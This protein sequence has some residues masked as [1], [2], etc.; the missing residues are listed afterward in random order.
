MTDARDVVAGVMDAFASVPGAAV[1]SAALLALL[2]LALGWIAGRPARRA[3]RW[4]QRRGRADLEAARRIEDPARL[5]G[6]LRGRDPYVF[7][8]LVLHAFRDAGARVRFSERK[9]GD[10]GI[11]GEIRSGGRRYAMQAKR[12]SGAIEP[13]HVRAFADV[14]R[15]RR[16]RYAG[17]VFVHT[18]RT[19][20][21]SRDAL[22]GAPIAMVS[23]DR[24]IDLVRG[25]G[26]VSEWLPGP[27]GAGG[28]AR[29]GKR[30]DG[31]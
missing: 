29:P 9:S 19:K 15:R 6:F 18:G 21:G 4:R 31:E 11:D 16:R 7:E 22:E 14:L 3:A 8:D 24:L 17:G 30:R 27:P 23:G 5:F 2:A 28:R 13:G 10:G 25:R 12:Y 1:G 20:Q 26:E